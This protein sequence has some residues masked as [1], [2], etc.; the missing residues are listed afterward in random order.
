M[1]GQ[2]YLYLALFFITAMLSITV[3]SRYAV[4]R[5]VFATTTLAD[6]AQ[7]LNYKLSASAAAF[8]LVVAGV[9]SK[10]TVDP[11]TGKSVFDRKEWDERY[12]WDNYTTKPLT[13]WWDYGTPPPSLNMTGFIVFKYASAGNGVGINFTVLSTSLYDRTGVQQ[14]FIVALDFARPGKSNTWIHSGYAILADRSGLKVYTFSNLE[15]AWS[16]INSNSSLLLQNLYNTFTPSYVSNPS[17]QKDKIAFAVSYNINGNLVIKEL[18]GNTGSR[19]T[20]ILAPPPPSNYQGAKIAFFVYGQG[21]TAALDSI[22]FRFTQEQVGSA[23][24]TLYSSLRSVQTVAPEFDLANVS[25]VLL[26]SF[27]GT[28]DATISQTPKRIDPA[29]N[30]AYYQ[31]TITESRAWSAWKS[32]VTVVIRGTNLVFGNT[33]NF[34]LYVPSVATETYKVPSLTY[35]YIVKIPISISLNDKPVQYY[36]Y[37]MLMHFKVLTDEPVNLLP[38]VAFA[39]KLPL[40]YQSQKGVWYVIHLAVPEDAVRN[41]ATLRLVV[42]LPEGVPVILKITPHF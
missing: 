12:L 4:P 39:E 24:Q 30:T 38:Y 1:K 23:L 25:T 27:N 10:V 5:V 34:T 42:T 16:E 40:T 19:Q 9:N 6:Q 8:R 37:Y 28:V 3:A 7:L 36:S 14:S 21:V 35:F 20:F 29:T 26:S 17:Y 15:K 22:V 11:S 41:R 32:N 31:T 33:Y 2:F 13:L 18:Y